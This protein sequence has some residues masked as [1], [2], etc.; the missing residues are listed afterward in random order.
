MTVIRR[1]MVKI[2]VIEVVMMI[3]EEKMKREW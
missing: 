3:V 2:T 1:V